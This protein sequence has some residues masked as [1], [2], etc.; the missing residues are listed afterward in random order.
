MCFED[1]GQ[2]VLHV[3]LP[4]LGYCVLV[5]TNM[6]GVFV[7]MGTLRSSARSIP[8]DNN[9]LNFFFVLFN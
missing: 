1:F 6:F 4:A 9:L 2:L 8:V 5:G 3:V 7:P